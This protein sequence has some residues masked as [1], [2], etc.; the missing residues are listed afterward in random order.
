MHEQY[1]D[2]TENSLLDPEQNC[3][4]LLSLANRLLED[5]QKNYGGLVETLVELQQL[6][7]GRVDLKEKYQD[8][9]HT[10][11][12][13]LAEIENQPVDVLSK[14]DSSASSTQEKPLERNDEMSDEAREA[15]KAQ[16]LVEDN[17]KFREL[18]ENDPGFMSNTQLLN[19]LRI[20]FDP[21]KP[22]DESKR[23]AARNLLN[24]AYA[25][26]KSPKKPT[27]TESTPPI[28]TPVDTRSAKSSNGED[29]NQKDALTAQR[30]QRRKKEELDKKIALYKSLLTSEE[31][32]ADDKVLLFKV[33]KSSN[34][35]EQERA[36]D[37]INK[38]IRKIRE[39]EVKNFNISQDYYA[40]LGVGRSASGD[41]IKSAFRKLARKF[42]TDLVGDLSPASQQKC[43]GIIRAINEANTIL[44]NP[45][46][47]AKYDLSLTPM[48]GEP[49]RKETAAARPIDDFNSFM[50]RIF[51]DAGFFTPPRSNPSKREAPQPYD[52]DEWKRREQ[53]ARVLE[54]ELI[55]ANIS[56]MITILSKLQKLN[57]V[58]EVT[59]DSKK[60]RISPKKISTL[61]IEAIDNI[62]DES[63]RTASINAL[64]IEKGIREK[65]K[66]ELEAR[67]KA[68]NSLKKRDASGPEILQALDVLSR[69]LR[70]IYTTIDG[71]SV[72][73]VP[74]TELDKIRQLSANHLN[75]NFVNEL[76]VQI[77]P[78][79]NIDLKMYYYIRE[80]A[81]GAEWKNAPIPESIAVRYKAYKSRREAP[82]TRF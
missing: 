52:I 35:A 21:P 66:A 74:K 51:E 30:E 62:D 25:D 2:S 11:K 56:Q 50:Y 33:V 15:Q 36:V 53:R 8:K 27:P 28:A 29:S 79:L 13:K 34:V 82:T 5:P 45:S 59:N 26:Y 63:K 19:E 23:V 73:V 65:V 80:K 16:Q 22:T 57:Y 39:R 61:I 10:L 38:H 32:G 20:L 69:T 77:T 37:F 43:E 76:I 46:E 42:H 75:S 31:L 81:Q 18:F 6:L 54:G 44:S 48:S 12:Q 49:R 3:Q 47:R 24:K 58:F 60:E 41:E 68:I 4:D 7:S 71:Q 64:P 70:E 14:V 9:V 40:L 67:I 1:G 78:W 55:N 17:R 72:T